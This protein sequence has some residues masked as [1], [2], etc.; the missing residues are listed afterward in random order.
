MAAPPQTESLAGIRVAVKQ[1]PVAQGNVLG[2]TGNKPRGFTEFS[3]LMPWS[4]QD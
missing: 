4:E 2:N 3:V 1:I